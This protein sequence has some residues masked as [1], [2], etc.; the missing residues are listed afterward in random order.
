MH[1]LCQL[2]A[3][4]L[5][6]EPRKNLVPKL[7]VTSRKQRVQARNTPSQENKRA[8]SV[9]TADPSKFRLVVFWGKE[10]WPLSGVL[11]FPESP[12]PPFLGLFSLMFF[13]LHN[14]P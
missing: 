3:L 13:Q 7:K 2:L 10:Y 6:P 11:S 8:G 1:L 4:P 9:L 12:A 5:P 14:T